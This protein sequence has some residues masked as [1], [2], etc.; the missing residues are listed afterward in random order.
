MILERGTLL[1]NRYRIVEILGQGGMGS[2]YRAVDENLGME[3]AVKDNSFTTEEYARQFRREA[4]ILANLRHPNLPRVTDHFVIASQ[5]QYLVM[6]YIEGEDLRQRMERI[7]PIPEDEVSLIG[8]AVCDALAYLGSR[9]PAI[10]HRD[11]KP[12]NVKITPQGHIFLVDFGLAK[13]LQGTQ[14]TTTGARA[15]T[16]GFSPPEQYGTARTDQRS[17]IFSL[18]ATL[19]AALTGATPEDALARAMDQ[20]TLTPLRKHNPKVSK[21]IA[22]A[23]EKALEVRPDLRYQTA[24]EFKQAL[25]A[26]S[27]AIRRRDG[28]Y[29]VSPPPEGERVEP[30]ENAL[31]PIETREKL[32]VPEDRSPSLLPLSTQ[33]EESGVEQPSARRRLSRSWGCLVALLFL[34]LALGGGGFY[35]SQYNPGLPGRL[36]NR[37]WPT[38]SAMTNLG[39]QTALGANVSPTA[40]LPPPTPSMTPTIKPAATATTSATATV[41]A[42]DTPIPTETPVPQP[43]PLGGGV[44]LIAFAS[45]VDGASQVFLIDTNGSHRKQIT[46]LPE[47]ACQPD[48][49]PDGKRIVF[50]SPCTSNQDAYPGSAMY[51]INEDGSGLLPLPTLAGGDF[52]PRWSPDGKRIVFTSLR[53]A[54][55]PQIY[56]LNLDINQ[57]ISLSER[58]NTDFNPSWSPD[59]KQI[60]FISNRRQGQ[61]VWIMNADGSDPR[62]YSNSKTELNYMPGWSPDYQTVIWTQLVAEGGVPR[63]MVAPFTFDPRSEYRISQMPMREAV[64]SP[65]G[66]WISFEGWQVS[67]NHNIYLM[68]STGVSLTPLTDDDALDFDPDWKPAPPIKP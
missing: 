26:S 39:Q 56:V 7:G 30:A 3:V 21:R 6:D 9:R 29:T 53:N 51:I 24:D 25:L 42:T 40:T 64:Y 1:N 4:L 38:V 57:V 37:F 46:N 66:Y 8:A 13:T 16:P 32:Y 18:G 62:Q 34:L 27:T 63:V 61:Q 17:D 15:M 23:I 60:I 2:V 54:G 31:V 44:G 49:S 5:G 12:G 33:I 11:I 50:I 59:G 10:I 43:T 20:A 14:A 47:G 35:V 58:Y 22:A 41:S 28:E 65:D 45:K 55:L 68:T 19:Y 67:G 48:W 52:D 36:Y